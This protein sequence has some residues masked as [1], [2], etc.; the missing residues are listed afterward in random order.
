MGCNLERVPRSEVWGVL[1]ELGSWGMD[2][3]K[4]SCSARNDDVGEKLAWEWEVLLPAG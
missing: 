1:A 3:R 2:P 4:S